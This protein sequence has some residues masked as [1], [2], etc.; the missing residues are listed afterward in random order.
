MTGDDDEADAQFAAAADA[1]T[2]PFDI[3][4]TQLLHRAR[5]RR[6]GRRTAARTRLRAARDGFAAMGLDGW[7]GRTDDELAASGENQRSAGAGRLT[8]RE[9][10]VGLMVA[11]GMSNREVAATLFISA[12]TVEHHV[13]GALHKLGL[14]TRTD[15]AVFLSR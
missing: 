14:R 11:Q 13:T 15:L 2:N 1:G 10:Q 4:R 12:R 6:A 3:A 7:I 9:T 8:S 5:L